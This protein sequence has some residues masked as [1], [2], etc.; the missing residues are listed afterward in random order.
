[1]INN[2]K[3]TTAAIPVIL[4]WEAVKKHY[5]IETGS[6]S[7]WIVEAVTCIFLNTSVGFGLIDTGTSFPSR[8][9]FSGSSNFYLLPQ[10]NTDPFRTALQNL[11]LDASEIHFALLSH[12]HDDHAGNLEVFDNG[13]VRIF[14]SPK[15]L[16][17][18]KQ[19]DESYL[20]KAGFDK[21]ALV[22]HYFLWSD[23][24]K[25]DFG[26]I[27]PISTPGH[28]PGHCS[29]MIETTDIGDGGVVFCCDAADLSENISDVKPPGICFGEKSEAKASLD[30]LISL[31]KCD[32]L[33]LIPGHDGRYWEELTTL[34]GMNCSGMTYL[35]AC[36]LKEELIDAHS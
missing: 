7:E 2:P 32:K 11:D 23:L 31:A 24:E 35:D 30:K 1:M 34:D 26:S 20:H 17:F 5:S 29:F 4:G 6:D 16:D 10:E 9:S 21:A 19:H 13:F 8:L 33:T 28:T 27:S 3:V 36:A 25:F 15:E 22:K 18:I 14:V 12:L